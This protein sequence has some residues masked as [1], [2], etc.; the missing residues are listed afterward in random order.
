MDAPRRHHPIWWIAAILGVVLILLVGGFV[1][2]Q[3][4][5]ACRAFSDGVNA[6]ASARLK[7]LYMGEGDPGA[8]NRAYVREGSS[9]DEIVRQLK[10]QVAFE[11]RDDR[12][13]GCV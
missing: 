12:P 9:Y 1:F 4:S 8:V 3:F 10:S 11:R 6:E 13:S 7:S 5:P 2:W